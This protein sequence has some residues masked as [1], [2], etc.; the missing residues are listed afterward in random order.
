MKLDTFNSISWREETLSEHV[1]LI[2]R[3]KI[4]K[5]NKGNNEKFKIL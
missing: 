4:S 5:G 1:G 2:S 3:N